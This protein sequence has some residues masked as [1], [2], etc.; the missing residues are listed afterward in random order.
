MPAGFTFSAYSS[1]F[2]NRPAFVRYLDRAKDSEWVVYAK[3]PFAG[4][5]H[6]LDYVGRY[7][8]RVAISNN[9]LLDMDNDQVRFRWKDYRHA[10]KVKTMTLC[11]PKNS[12]GVSC[13]M[14]CRTVCNAFAI[15]DFLRVGDERR[16][17]PSAD[18]CSGCR[19]RNPPRR[20]WN[21]I[22]AIGTRN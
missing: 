15:T 2:V 18:I 11:L 22:T 3:R 5:Q 17:S 1:S 13:S 4:P 7:T 20:R 12:S 9:R 16:N 6:V 14:Y 8:H 19:R 10:D 21:R